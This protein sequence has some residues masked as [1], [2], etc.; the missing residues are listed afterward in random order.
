[1]FLKNFEWK[2]CQYKEINPPSLKTSTFAGNYD[3]Q[4]GGQV[5]INKKERGYDKI[6]SSLHF[7]F[8]FSADIQ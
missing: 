5:L 4:V 3:G 8:D 1:M 6:F 2:F 7:T